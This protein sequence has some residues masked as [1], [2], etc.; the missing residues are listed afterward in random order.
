MPDSL[1]SIRRLNRLIRRRNDATPY[2][3]ITIDPGAMPR[4]SEGAF[5]RA[6]DAEMKA[7]YAAQV[8]AELRAQSLMFGFF[9][10]E[11]YRPGWRSAVAWLQERERQRQVAAIQE[12]RV[13]AEWPWPAR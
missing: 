2:T 6:F 1:P 3:P 12:Q 8:K 13:S 9:E 4:A 7:A 5:V 10:D 11:S